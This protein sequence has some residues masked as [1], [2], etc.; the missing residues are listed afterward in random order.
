M[1]EYQESIINFYNAL[2][3]SMSPQSVALV[4]VFI[5]SLFVSGYAIFTWKFYKFLARKDILKLNLSQYNPSDHPVL[6]KTLAACLYLIEYAVILPFVIFFWFA[7]LSF[8]ILLISEGSGALHVLYIS[9]A[10]VTSIRILSYYEEELA[11][12]IAKL[13]PLTVLAIF[14]AGAGSFSVPTLLESLLEIPQFA[15]SIL[16]F[17]A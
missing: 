16:Y 8:M 9:A 7:I 15:T 17:L 12:E 13:L 10:I 1:I 6:R 2:T 11:V 14:V 3:G 5:F 4:N